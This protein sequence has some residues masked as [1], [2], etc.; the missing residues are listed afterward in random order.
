MSPQ[1]LPD[2]LGMLVLMCVLAWLRRQHK[3]RRVGGWLSGLYFI[4]IEMIATSVIQGSKLLPVAMHIVALNT[5]LLA[6]VAF[7]REAQRER[8]S[9]R[10]H[11][12]SY[13]LAAIPLSLLA[14]MMA[15]GVQTR[16]PYQAVTSLSLALGIAYVLL[17]PGWHYRQRISLGTIHLFLWLPMSA[18]AF[19]SQPEWVVYSGLACLYFL[20]ALS[21]RPCIRR[22][23]IGG[24]LIIVSF[25]VW[26]LCFLAYPL[27]QTRPLLDAIVEQI[28]NIQKFFVVIGMLLV[29]LEDETQRRRDEAMHDAL[30]GLPNRRLFEDRLSLALERSRRSGLSAAVF[31]IDLDH[32]K[33]INDT[34]G[35]DVGDEI[36]IRVSERLKS[37]LRGSDTIARCGGDE[38]KVVVNDLVRPDNCLRIAE[39][40]QSAIE[41]IEAPQGMQG[42]MSGSIGYAIYPN[43]SEDTAELCRIADRRMYQAKRLQAE[44]VAKA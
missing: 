10:G 18:F 37:N 40:L 28:W 15:M 11:P 7:G 5:Y 29:L 34:C 2:I 4:L 42:T 6:A 17:F 19:A 24:W 41:E 33:T 32:F 30:T 1:S 20:V 43:D 38:F 31:V 39:A 22:G 12:L 3:D 44:V 35:H 14:T 25:S 13:L 8:G 23:C 16:W 9:T 27:V 36:L 21:F 26:A